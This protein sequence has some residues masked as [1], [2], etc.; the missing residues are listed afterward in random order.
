MSWP[1][2]VSAAG[3]GL[4]LRDLQES[5]GIPR[6]LQ[7]FPGLPQSPQGSLEIPRTSLGL[8]PDP[9]LCSAAALCL[10][11]VACAGALLR[12]STFWAWHMWGLRRWQGF[13]PKGGASRPLP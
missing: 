7:E 12:S 8:T 3:T 10:W 2:V 5:L 11:A 4:H 9:S 1:L 13:R 6:A